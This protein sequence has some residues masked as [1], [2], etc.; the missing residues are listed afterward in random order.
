MKNKK[1]FW[2]AASIILLVVVLFF[3]SK[4]SENQRSN[5]MDSVAYA[6]TWVW[7]KTIMTDGTIISPEKKDAFT[8]NFTRDGRISG[9]TD[10]NSFMGNVAVGR[11]NTLTFGQ[12]ASTLMFCE[13]SQEAQFTNFLSNVSAYMIDDAD[14]LVLLLRLDSGSVYFIKQR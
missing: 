4:T 14:N 6:S 11:N 5:S 13:N 9:T 10:C 12:L 7:E 2:I 1:V 3:L 8:I